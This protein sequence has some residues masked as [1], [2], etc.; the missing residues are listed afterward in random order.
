MLDDVRNVRLYFA[1]CR[2]HDVHSDILLHLS[3]IFL[4]IITN[5]NVT[6]KLTVHY[7][8]PDDMY[9]LSHAIVP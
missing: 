7:L 6:I 3:F 1:D 2:L 5:L 8:S 9:N 4:Q